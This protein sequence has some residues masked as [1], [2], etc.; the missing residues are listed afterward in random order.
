MNSREDRL[1]EVNARGL[2]FPEAVYVGK[3]KGQWPVTVFHTIDRVIDWLDGGPPGQRFV[4]R[5]ELD[6]VARVTLKPPVAA[7]IEEVS[8]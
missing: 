1:N 3:V 4:Y 2:E 6:P 7:T 8:L 5:C